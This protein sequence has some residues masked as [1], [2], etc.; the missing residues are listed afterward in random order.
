[1]CWHLLAIHHEDEVPV[2]PW[3]SKEHHYELLPH[4]SQHFR[5]HHP[6]QRMSQTEVCATECR[7]ILEHL[8]LIEIFCWRVSP[9]LTIYS[10][11]NNLKRSMH[12][13]SPLCLACA[14]SSSLWPPSCRGVSWWLQ[15]SQVSYILINDS[16]IFC[17][18]IPSSAFCHVCLL[19]AV[20]ICWH[21]DRR[22]GAEGKGP[23]GGAAEHLIE[24]PLLEHPESS[25]KASV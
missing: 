8:Q 9:I 10:F 11:C 5:L 17:L 20:N 14:P 16:T 24:S 19:T 7:Q 6:I 18:R 22:P 21:R 25:W 3:G 1:M 13:P 15:T 4:P 12:S 23:G 2:H